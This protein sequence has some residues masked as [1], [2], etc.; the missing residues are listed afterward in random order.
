MAK[1]VQKRYL[2]LED[3][4]ADPSVHVFDGKLYIYPSHDW[5]SA[6]P[7]DDFGSEYD[8]KDYHVLSLE[9]PDPMT[10]PIKDNGKAI[11][12]KDIPWA[13]RQ[14]WDNDVV[15]GR[16][17]RYYMY[18]PA[19]DKTDIFR[20]GVAISDSP[21]GPFVPQPDP[22]RG[23]YSIDYA[24]LHDDDDEYYMYFGGIWGGQLQRY[25]NNMAKDCGTSYPADDEPAIPARV[26]KLGKDMLQFAE[27]PKPVVLLDENGKPITVADNNRRFFEASW[28]HK[29][30]GKYY[31][32]YSTGDTHCI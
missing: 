8:M 18:F 19:K 6:A 26:V 20:C 32:S 22:I 17:G 7:D 9:G 11:D 5:E 3:Y 15:K 2:F 28:M 29:Y 13:G 1:K 30:N 10:S 21:V 14:L 23:S 4:M 16:D 27:A 24:V 12:I 31:F 25:E